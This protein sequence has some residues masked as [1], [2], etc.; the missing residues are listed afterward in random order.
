[1][2]RSSLLALALASA[3]PALAQA[4]PTSDI[5]PAPPAP[6]PGSSGVYYPGMPVPVSSP[7]SSTPGTL[8]GPG[9]KVPA[10][11]GN[12]IYDSGAYFG[13][14]PV[15]GGRVES[16]QIPE[17]HVVRKGDTLWEIAAYYFRNPWAWPKLW[18]L[19]PSITNPHWIYPG[20]LVRLFNPSA[21]VQVA[22]P[23]AATPERPRAPVRTNG[24]FL[25]QTGFIEPDELKSAGKIIASKEEKIMLGALDEAYVEM[26]KDRPLRVGERYTVFRLLNDVKHPVTKKKVGTLVQI[27]GEAEVKTVTDGNIAR[28]VIV[29]SIDPIERGYMVGPLRRQFKVVEP[30][31]N[32]RELEGVVVVGLRPLSM[33]ASEQ[34]MFID[35]GKSD[36][37]VP[38]NR[39]FV[40]RRGDGYQPLLASGPIDD[41]RFPRE[42]IAEI[43]IID[44]RQ[45]LA[46]GLVTH[47][48]HEARVGDRVEARKGY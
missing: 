28:C 7:P 9:D 46:T 45:Q 33:V 5:M 11:R 14:V 35:L 17:V 41:R 22:V 8:S 44:T 25:R 39:F 34:L 40:T 27:M 3:L 16:G 4:Q 32:E 43:L 36:G 6:P 37:V 19:N 13:G 24:V 15:E 21:P 10:R 29:D 30:V 47:S 12:D 20:D 2:N 18:A 26:K 38:G 1:M 31:R 42:I 23:A 48:S